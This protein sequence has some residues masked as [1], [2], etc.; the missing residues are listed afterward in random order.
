M[1]L[2]INAKNK[3]KGATAMPLG[4]SAGEKEQSG[5]EPPHSKALRALPFPPLV[6]RTGLVMMAKG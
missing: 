5:V 6:N 2:W 4:I 1:P 3:D